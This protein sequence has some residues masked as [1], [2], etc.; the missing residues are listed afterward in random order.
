MT[1]GVNSGYELGNQKNMDY[2]EICKIYTS[3]A[4]KSVC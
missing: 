4:K 2:S 3:I 1:I